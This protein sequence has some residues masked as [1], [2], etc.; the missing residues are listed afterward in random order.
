MAI[1]HIYVAIWML[2]FL[3]SSIRI[4]TYGVIKRIWIAR[5]PSGYGFIDFDDRKDAQD[6]IHH[7]NG[8]HNWKLEFSYYSGDGDN[9]SGYVHGSGKLGSGNG[10][11]YSRTHPSDHKSPDKH[12]HLS[13]MR[14]SRRWNR[15]N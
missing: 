9:C 10:L 7:L 4:R 3:S 2:E 15:E 14:F 5:K 6:A 12:L 1:S 8:K 11:R 13:T